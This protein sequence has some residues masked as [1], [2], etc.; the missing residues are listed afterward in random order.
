VVDVYIVFRLLDNVI[1]ALVSVLVYNLHIHLRLFP[2][3]KIE[4][5][6][7]I[8]F[9]MK[10]SVLFFVGTLSVCSFYSSH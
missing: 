10:K 2:W 9:C 6:M 7:L 4:G 3:D 5:L 8:L 1:N